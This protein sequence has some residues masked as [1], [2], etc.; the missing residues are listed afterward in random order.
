MNDLS[1]MFIEKSKSF[2]LRLHQDRS[3]FSQNFDIRQFSQSCFST[4]SKKYYFIIENLFEMFDEKFKKK[5][6][7]QSQNN[8]FFR[9]FSNQMRI[10]AYF[11]SAINQK[12]S[13][14]QNSKSSKSKSLNQ[15]MFAKFIR[16]NFSKC[17]EKSI[18]LSYKMSNIFY[19]K[20]K[21][22][23]QS[24][25]SSRF[26]FTWF[27]FTFSSSFRSSSSNFYLCCICFDQ[28]SFNSWLH[29]HLRASHQDHSLCQSMRILN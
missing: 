19:I 5:N 6:L 7:F 24:R 26:S 21:I 29:K 11:K 10:I 14:N 20:S 8:V 25:F 23:L 3:Y 15:H 28:F 13:I 27:S 18:F 4:A 1:R 22:F 2:D 16:I 12:L 9:A 17:F